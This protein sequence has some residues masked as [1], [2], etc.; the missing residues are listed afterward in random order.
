M[1]RPP[2]EQGADRFVTWG[3]ESMTEQ[4]AADRIEQCVQELPDSYGSVET[5]MYAI[6]DLNRRTSRGAPKMESRRK[7]KTVKVVIGGSEAPYHIYLDDTGTWS[8]EAGLE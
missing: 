3:G 5:L 7:R 2:R 4:E 8:V 6:A 1:K